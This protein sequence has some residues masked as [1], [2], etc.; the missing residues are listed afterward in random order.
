MTVQSGKMGDALSSELLQ[1]SSGTTNR[2]GVR[3][4][5][6]WASPLPHCYLTSSGGEAGVRRR[7][8]GGGLLAACRVGCRLSR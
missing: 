7:D 5:V 4:A 2:E 1:T 8:D 3:T 6:L